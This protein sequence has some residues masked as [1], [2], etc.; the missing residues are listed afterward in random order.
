VS[1]S[2]ES[3]M[4]A[5]A[6]GKANGKQSVIARLEDLEELQ[7]EIERLRNG[8]GEYSKEHNWEIQPATRQGYTACWRWSH[9]TIE[10]PSELAKGLLE[11]KP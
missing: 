7:A 8:L 2:L 10:D 4:R 9:N 1:P 11:N 3:L 5:V 6:Y